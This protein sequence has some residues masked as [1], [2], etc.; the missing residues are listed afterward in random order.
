VKFPKG[1]PLQTT[2]RDR[3]QRCTRLFPANTS[4]KPSSTLSEFHRLVA[5]LKA[6][7]FISPI[8]AL[9]SAVEN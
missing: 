8:R 9:A 7:S 6:P 2:M 3:E 5:T 1:I 4:E